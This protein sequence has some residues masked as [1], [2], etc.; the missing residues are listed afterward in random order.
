MQAKLN[1]ELDKTKADGVLEAPAPTFIN[2][3]NKPNNNT[4][5]KKWQRVLSAFLD[6]KTFNRFESERLLN[7]HCL[8]STVS[9]LERSG[10]TIFRKF[11]TVSGW[12]GLPTRVCR[13]W[14]DNSA[15]NINRA[16]TLLH[17]SSANEGVI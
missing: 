1:Q 11:E 3:L 16:N 9:F 5:P 10:V 15:E 14:I 8:H 12:Q 17:R 7:D 2:E 4:P 6:D 13:Y